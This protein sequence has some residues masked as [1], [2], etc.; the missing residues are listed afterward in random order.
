[1]RR[2]W[3]RWLLK[4]GLGSALIVAMARAI[5]YGVLLH[6]DANT[7]TWLWITA[8]CFASILF[9]EWPRRPARVAAIERRDLVAI[10]SVFG[11][12]LLLD[13]RG[14]GVVRI[15]ELDRLRRYFLIEVPRLE[16]YC[17]GTAMTLGGAYALLRRSGAETPLVAPPGATAP[18]R[19]S[20]WAIPAG[21]VLFGLALLATGWLS[22]EL[23]QGAYGLWMLWIVAAAALI[24]VVGGFLID[25]GTWRMLDRPA[26]SLL[27]GALCLALTAIGGVIATWRVDRFPYV[28][29]GDEGAF[30]EV[31]QQLLDGR[32]PSFFGLGVYTF[33][34]ASNHFQAAIMSIVG[35]DFVGW[36]MSSALPYALAAP[37]IYVLGRAASGRLFACCATVTLIT[38]PYGLAYARIGYN[39]SQA[40]PILAGTLACGWFAYQR[41]SFGAMALAGVVAGL[42]FGTYTGARL[43]AVVMLILAIQ[44]G[45]HTLLA[46]EPVRSRLANFLRLGALQLVFA[47]ALLT[48]V[49]PSTVY[50]YRWANRSEVTHKIVEGLFFNRFYSSYYFP[51]SELYRD[52]PP[53]PFGSGELF[54]RS[55][56]WFRLLGRG[57]VHFLEFTMSLDMAMTHLVVT[58]YA[59]AAI[60]LLAFLVGL[61]LAMRSRRTIL[62]A[63]VVSTFIAGA[64]LLSITNSFPPRPAHFVPVTPAIA[65]LVGWGLAAVITRLAPPDSS[66]RWRRIAVP[67]IVC[68]AL[69][70]TSLRTTFVEVNQ[71]FPQR[72]LEAMLLDSAVAPHGGRWVIVSNDPFPPDTRFW[73]E[74]LQGSQ[75]VTSV[76]PHNL[77]A[78]MASLAPGERLTIYWLSI[79]HAAVW[80][81]IA[82]TS[83]ASAELRI[84]TLADGYRA[85]YSAVVVGDV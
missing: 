84:L 39:N 80:P 58:S 74:R 15:A 67:V 40:V 34:A 59:G 18:R 26:F 65:L 79:D 72:P 4:V 38:L 17:P 69:I 52:Y 57:A 19:P 6:K 13:H 78:Y 48:V 35:D 45:F 16:D 5:D 44:A 43:G 50:Q 76:R 81:T 33:P 31:G 61:C 21:I 20:R 75:T 73:S 27:D 55:D 12:I 56:L 70:I 64:V 85:G 71:R 51:A 66:R 53:L 36:R 41:R 1:M 9:P 62:G 3:V 49:L 77:A 47:A 8:G 14:E 10:A 22:R 82:A 54:F 29:N 25:R 23:Y 63:L 2:Q 37:P 68:G 83:G 7:H 24:A 32:G 42:G 28:L 60:G 30:W 46:R 11:G